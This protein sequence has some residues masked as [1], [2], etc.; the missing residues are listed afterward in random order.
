MKNVYICLG[1]TTQFMII[2][3]WK[4][5]SVFCDADKLIDIVTKDCKIINI[6]FFN[7]RSLKIKYDFFHQSFD[8][9]NAKFNNDPN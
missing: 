6:C 4:L 5:G 7:A 9:V 1:H 2:I 8:K 3:I